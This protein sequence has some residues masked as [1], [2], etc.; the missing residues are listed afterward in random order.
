LRAGFEHSQCWFGD[1]WE[2]GMSIA[3]TFVVR[4]KTLHVKAA[5]KDDSLEEVRKYS[6]AILEAART[7]G[8]TSVLSDETDLVY[9][10]GVMDT[11]E[12]AKFI[13]EIA[14]MMCKAAVVCHPAQIDDA[15]FWETVAVNRGVLVRVFKTAR[16]AEQWLAEER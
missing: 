7:A 13:S 9:T 15:A 3:Y 2:E 8:C 5:G 1:E 4:N 10:L 12:S 16:E 11:F 6:L 14:P